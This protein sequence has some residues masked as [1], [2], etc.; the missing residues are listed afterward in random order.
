MKIRF[1]NFYRHL[2]K[3][4]VSI[5][6]T[7][8][9]NYLSYAGYALAQQLE[10]AGYIVVYNDS[11]DIA[12]FIDI[13]EELYQVAKSL[14]PNVKKILCLVE[15]PIYAP[16]GHHPNILFSDIW[17]RVLTYNREFYSEKLTYYDI[18]V[19]GIQCILP[20]GPISEMSKKGVFIGSFKDDRGFGLER[21]AMIL[22][23]ADAG[24]L[25]IWGYGWPPCAG[26]HGTTDNKIETLRQY[27]YSLCVENAKFSGYVTE[28]IGDSILAGR[29]C[30]YFG[31]TVHARRRFGE[32]F[33]A[34][35]ELSFSS[36]LTA[37]S[38]IEHRYE[39]L[40]GVVKKEKAASTQWVDPYLSA[41]TN[42]IFSCHEG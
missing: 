26:Y 14:P 28:K 30:M 15:S 33:V 41:M 36:Y 35:Q 8:Y 24:L 38:E 12:I 27:S 19:T 3:E 22:Q 17:A 6:N 21:N 16:F 29:P 11:F 10:Q 4:V 40:V 1:F 32:S 13:D 7:T 18:P 20:G 9:G 2:D 39:E 25:D 42:A 37:K 34:L 31:D 5:G 23:A